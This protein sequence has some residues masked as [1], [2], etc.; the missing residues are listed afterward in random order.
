MLII[1]FAN[2]VYSAMKLQDEDLINN[3]HWAREEHRKIQADRDY[4]SQWRPVIVYL[5]MLGDCAA[6]EI[7]RRGL[8]VETNLILQIPAEPFPSYWKDIEV[9]DFI[10][11]LAA[12]SGLKLYGDRYEFWDGVYPEPKEEA[13]ANPEESEAAGA[14]E[15]T[16]DAE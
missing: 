7:Q 15:E 6:R 16:S 1:P 11:G 14:E 4:E 10:E 2:P 9:P 3:F 5:M 12:E 13:A 8:D